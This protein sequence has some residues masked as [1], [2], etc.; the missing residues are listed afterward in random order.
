M[1]EIDIIFSSSSSFLSANMF[2]KFSYW[3]TLLFVFFFFSFEI[4]TLNRDRTTWFSSLYSFGEWVKKDFSFDDAKKLEKHLVVY[5]IDLIESWYLFCS[6]GLYFAL[7]SVNDVSISLSDSSTHSA[8]FRTDIIELGEKT[9]EERERER[10]WR[11]RTD[12]RR[13]RRRRIE[14]TSLQS[15]TF[16]F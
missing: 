7:V 13:R 5:E 6:L 16:F 2:T 8:G 10:N 14:D 15:T 1:I 9:E 12:R 3:L 11:T 4:R